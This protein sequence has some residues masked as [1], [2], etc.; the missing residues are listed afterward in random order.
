MRGLFYTV[1]TQKKDE[2]DCGRSSKMTP[3][4]N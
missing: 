2:E 3:G 4:G 1:V